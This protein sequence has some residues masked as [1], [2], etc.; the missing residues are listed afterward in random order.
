MQTAREQ[1]IECALRGP[2]RVVGERNGWPVGVPVERKNRR[3]AAL[4]FTRELVE[5]LRTESAREAARRLEVNLTTISRFRG[6]L[7]IERMTPGTRALW[8]GE[9]ARRRPPGRAAGESDSGKGE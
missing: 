4:I 7:G 8:T 9:H 5:L 1:V 2:M 6:R 3:G